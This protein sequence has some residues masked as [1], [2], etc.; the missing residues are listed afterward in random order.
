MKKFSNFSFLRFSC[1]E[2]GF[3]VFFTREFRCLLFLH[4]RM[5]PPAFS[6]HENPVAC[7]FF[8][9]KS[10]CLFFLHTRFP[11]A[12]S[13]QSERTNHGEPLVGIVTLRR[14]LR[15]DTAAGNPF[16]ASCN[17][18][19]ANLGERCSR[20]PLK[21]RQRRA[22]TNLLLTLRRFFS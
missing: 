15:S 18:A 2:T 5:S 16:R 9:R 11:L 17:S 22:H 8:T 4:T 6:S 21:R 12:L 13:I 1:E 19:P 20:S 14:R 3:R 7:F 10:R